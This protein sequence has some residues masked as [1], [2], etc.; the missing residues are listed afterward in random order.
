MSTVRVDGRRFPVTDLAASSYSH[1]V[2]ESRARGL[3]SFKWLHRWCR[4]I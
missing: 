3:T 4:C 2:D 1:M